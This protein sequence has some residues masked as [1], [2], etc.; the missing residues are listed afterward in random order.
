MPLQTAVLQ[1]GVALGTTSTTLYTVPTAKSAWV[2]VAVMTNTSAASVNVTITITRA[3]GAPIIIT[4]ATPIPA[5][6]AYVVREMAGQALG[7]GDVVSAFASTAGTV[8]A[9]L[10]GLST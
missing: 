2:K 4:P 1:G 7:A 5:S 9:F 8:N 10:S 3:A 6:T